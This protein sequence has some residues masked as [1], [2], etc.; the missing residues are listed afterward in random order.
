MKTFCLE[1]WGD[2]ACF[3]RPENK[4]ERVS[5]DIITP[6]AARAIFEA[7]FW[8]PEIHWQI[9]KVCV[10]KPI[11]WITVR[12]NEVSEVIS[13]NNVKT[14]MKRGQSNLGLY[15]E[16]Y[17]QQRAGLILRD[18]AYY[19]YASLI[20]N[21]ESSM[22]DQIKYSEMFVRR[23]KSGQC[24]YQPYFGCREFPAYFS[25]SNNQTEMKVPADETR[26]LGLMLNDID[27][28]Q[29]KYLAQF[30]HAQLK[31]GIVDIPEWAEMENKS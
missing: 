30:F 14:A 15:I 3:T 5:Y 4:A 29:G 19:L 8:K 31:H 27:Y 26:D 17:R 20:L 23:A 9:M 16:D 11:R 2:Y 10:L 25:F 1:V 24:F 7:I 28:S 18:V 22:D 6:S 12:R 13:M 21:K